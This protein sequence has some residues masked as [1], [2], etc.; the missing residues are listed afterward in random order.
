MEECLNGKQRITVK[1]LVY[2][3]KKECFLEVNTVTQKGKICIMPVRFFV[4]LK[5]PS[6]VY[7]HI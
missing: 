4:I 3:W 6:I 5:L 7:L 2:C 1:G